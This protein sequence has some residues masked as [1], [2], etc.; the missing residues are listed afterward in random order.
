MS[1]GTIN[2]AFEDGDRA[3]MTG[4]TIGRVDMKLDNNVFE[5]SGGSIIN[6][7]VTGFGRGHDHPVGWQHR[8]PSASAVAMTR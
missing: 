5:M 3:V 8:G 7:L 4:G 6:N 2:R 1:G